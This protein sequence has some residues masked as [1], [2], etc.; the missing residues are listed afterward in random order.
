MPSQY[1]QHEYRGLLDLTGRARK[2]AGLE[3]EGP[4]VRKDG[5]Q[6]PLTLTVTVTH[7]LV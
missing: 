4:W 6:K 1:Y 2:M 3:Q 5:G 7:L